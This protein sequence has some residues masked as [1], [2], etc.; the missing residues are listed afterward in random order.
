M[1]TLVVSS[2]VAATKRAG[3]KDSVQEQKE[4]A[5]ERRHAL[6]EEEQDKRRDHE[7]AKKKL[8]L[9]AIQKCKSEEEAAKALDEIHHMTPEQA[10]S[11]LDVL[12]ARADLTL[13]D[14][15]AAHFK[16]GLGHLLDFGLGGRGC[17]ATKFESD[18][19]LHHALVDELGFAASFVNNKMRIALCVSSDTLT[20]FQEARKKKKEEESNESKQSSGPGNQPHVV[21][22]GGSGGLQPTV[23]AT[24]SSRDGPRSGHRLEDH[25]AAV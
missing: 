23:S 14:K 1:A 9:I 6:M 21:P 16:N 18:E 7:K 20:G 15:I 10:N 12:M 8:R 25:K 22:A 2:E 17:I 4:A 5:K 11:R 13:V 24:V 3:P 19:A